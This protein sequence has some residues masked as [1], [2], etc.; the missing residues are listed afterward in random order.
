LKKGARLQLSEQTTKITAH[1][2]GSSS[3]LDNVS[4]RQFLRGAAA[5]I[6]VTSLGA[7]GFADAE[8]AHAAAIRPF[9]LAHTTETRNTCPYCAVACGIIMYAK[10]VAENGGKRSIMHIEGDPDHPT[11]RGTLCPKGAALLEFVRAPTR[12]TKPRYRASGAKEWKEVSWD[13][14]LDRVARNLKDD[15]DKNLVT[16]NTAG[17]TVNRWLTTGFLAASAATNETGWLTF[18]VVRGAGALAFDNQ[19]RV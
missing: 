18:K 14:A 15:R 13:W 6:A 17:V 12:L 2:A 7:F 11:N 4:R 5:T 10:P 19:A 1:A 16:T 3:M 8:A 9:K